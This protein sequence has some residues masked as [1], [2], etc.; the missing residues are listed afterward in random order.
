MWDWCTIT[1]CY[2]TVAWTCF[3]IQLATNRGGRP[4]L[5]VLHRVQEI[6]FNA[7]CNFAW[8]HSINILLKRIING[9]AVFHFHFYLTFAFFP[10]TNERRIY[11][12]LSVR[13]NVDLMRCENYENVLILKLLQEGVPDPPS[14]SSI[15]RL[16]RGTDRRDD[17]G[18]KDYSI[19][20][21]LG[22]KFYNFYNFFIFPCNT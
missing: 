14:V 12:I 2:N 17:D 6:N 10:L 11:L 20:G 18:R 15:N 19:H 22:G 9:F 3:L 16:L 21:I 4:T 7:N 13:R 1:A 8:N 5:Y